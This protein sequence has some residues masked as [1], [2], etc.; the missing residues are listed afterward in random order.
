[1]AWHPTWLHDSEVSMCGVNKDPIILINFC[2][3]EGYS[4][5]MVRQFGWFQPIPLTMGDGKLQ[6]AD[7][8]GLN[9]VQNLSLPEKVAKP[10]RLQEEIEGYKTEIA[11]L[12]RGIILIL[13]YSI[14][15]YIVYLLL[16]IYSV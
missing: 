12:P 11:Q 13:M 15:I 7:N 8:Y 3:T 4:L 10:T 1:M 9:L 5:V 2:G 6:L 16:A 14:W